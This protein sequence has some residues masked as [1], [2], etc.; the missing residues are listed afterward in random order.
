MS[1]PNLCKRHSTRGRR[2]VHLFTSLQ[3]RSP[4]FKNIFWVTLSL[5][6]VLSES[7]GTAQ[8]KKLEPLIVSYSSFTGNRAPFWIAKTSGFMKNMAWM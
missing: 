2:I 7:I 6:L 8:E 3:K 1:S 5:V 4:M